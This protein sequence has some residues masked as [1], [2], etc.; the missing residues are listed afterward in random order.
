[1]KVNSS[2]MSER[3]LRNLSRVLVNSSNSRAK[4]TGHLHLL[5]TALSTKVS[6]HNINVRLR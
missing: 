4:K 3:R 2:S 5:T 6:Y 1:M